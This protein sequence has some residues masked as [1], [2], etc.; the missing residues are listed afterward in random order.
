ML[1][2][3]RR[4]N[5]LIHHLQ[6]LVPSSLVHHH[7]SSAAGGASSQASVPRLVV[8][9]GVAGGASVAA[10]ARRLAED[11]DITVLEKGSDVSFANCGMPYH[12]GNTITD[13]SKLLLHTPQSLSTLLKLKVRANT[14]ATKIDREKKLVHITV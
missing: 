6:P 9:G 8:I 2:H 4:V 7:F 13:P 3:S 10:R 14:A 11:A 12:I 5:T 1:S